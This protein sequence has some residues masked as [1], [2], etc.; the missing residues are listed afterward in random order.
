MLDTFTAF[1]E[2]SQDKKTFYNQMRKKYNNEALKNPDSLEACALF[3]Y[4][5]T[6]VTEKNFLAKCTKFVQN[7]YIN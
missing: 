1:H 5:N 7:S 2:L 6:E 4:L 3:M